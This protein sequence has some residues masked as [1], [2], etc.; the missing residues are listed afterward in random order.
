MWACAADRVYAL[1]FLLMYFITGGPPYG[2]EYKSYLIRNTERSDRIFYWSVAIM[3]FQR[4]HKGANAGPPVKLIPCFLLLKL[5]LLFIEYMLL[6]RPVQSFIVGLCGNINATQQYMNVWAIEGDAAMDGRDVSR[7]VATTFLKHTNLDLR[8]I[9]YRHLVTY[10]GG[11]IKQ[12]YYTKFPIDETSGHSSA[13][14][15]RHYA[16]CSNDHRFMNSQQMYT[17]KLS[18][19][20]FEASVRMRLAF[21]KVGTWSPP[22]S[23]AENKTPC[24]EV[25]C[26][27]LK[28][29]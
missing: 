22:S 17:Y 25:F 6:M 3:T 24:L 9:D 28:R 4:Y 1:L 10:F 16:N 26:I 8:I 27:L 29:P 14:A 15:A 2:E 19:P 21:P 12:S 20:H 7:L 5:T 11:T 13:M 23:I 18:Q